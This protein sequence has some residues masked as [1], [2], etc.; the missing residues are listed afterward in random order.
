MEDGEDILNGAFDEPLISK[1]VSTEM[2]KKV[3]NIS[4]ENIYSYDPVIQTEAAG[5]E[6][7]PGLLKTFFLALSDTKKASSQKIL[8]L[9][10]K[11]LIFDFNEQK[12]TSIMNVTAYVAG[13]TDSFAVNLYRVLKGIQLPNF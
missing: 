6:V 8:S 12:Y 4:R 11:D 13:M 5:F 2:V 3:N 9:I 10:P 7:L 1:V